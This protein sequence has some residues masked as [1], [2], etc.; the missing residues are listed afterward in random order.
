MT[1]QKSCSEKSNIVKNYGFSGKYFLGELK[2]SWPFA[3]FLFIAF[4]IMMPVAVLMG[5]QNVP[6]YIPV[7]RE[8]SDAE[9]LRHVMRIIEEPVMRVVWGVFIVGFGILS[10]LKIGTAL[11]NKVHSD[12]LHSLPI[13]RE[14]IFAT[15][16]L[17]TSAVFI[18]ALLVNSL[19]VV[20][21]CVVSSGLGTYGLSDIFAT[22]FAFFFKAL[23]LY[24]TAFSITNLA[25]MLSGTIVMQVFLTFFLGFAPLAYYLMVY[26]IAFTYADNISAD[27]YYTFDFSQKICPIVKQINMLITDAS[28]LDIFSAIFLNVLLI[29]ITIV[30]YK[31]RKVERAGTPVVFEPVAHVL[32][33]LCLIPCTFFVGF[34]FEAMGGNDEG[35]RIVGFIFGALLSFMF[36]NLILTKNARKMF[37]G[38]KG[39]GIYVAVMVLVIVGCSLNLF[40]IDTYV[41]K[42]DDLESVT[43]SVNGVA[44]NLEIREYKL[45]SEIL[46]TYADYIH[47]G[48]SETGGSP[49][50]YV[51]TADAIY[52]EVYEDKEI[53]KDSNYHYNLVYE[54]AE[55]ETY[56]NK[57]SFN[58]DNYRIGANMKL[59]FKLENGVKFAVK[60]H[61]SDAA[62]RTE[63]ARK[64]A[65]SAEFS[66][67][68]VKYLDMDKLSFASWT[69]LIK[70]TEELYWYESDNR[71]EEDA[72]MLAIME[73]VKAEYS[74]KNVFENNSTVVGYLSVRTKEPRIELEIPVFA[75]F[76]N[77]QLFTGCRDEEELF[78]KLSNM[79]EFMVICDISKVDSDTTVND[80]SVMITDNEFM[81]Q[82]FSAMHSLDS[83]YNSSYMVRDEQY[84]IL[85]GIKEAKYKYY[86]EE[87]DEYHYVTYLTR[88]EKG[89]VPE[90]VSGF[91]ASL[92][93]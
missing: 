53:Y 42:N 49:S 43:V 44:D 19:L 17:T 90:F 72:R 50:V 36:M 70:L 5:L 3:V 14:A 58:S 84:R 45:K 74:K 65:E 69:P 63:L 4:L 77:Q 18:G 75:S 57:I 12:F 82:A 67:E 26:G 20:L 83:D 41:P 51:E 46:R 9:I 87:P 81:R 2:R 73:A 21:A 62:K 71:P 28:A 31:M 93:K 11:T 13:R 35:W 78:V 23:L 56:T 22:V 8:I 80:C 64:I 52:Y 61:L 25:C 32:K 1:T 34:L 38:I 10:G 66:K 15:K 92:I 40:G 86:E 48:G 29:F 76:E 68:I 89:N 39:F 27:Y 59:V 54:N 79:A 7:V 24:F 55:G 60:M 91:L 33:Y 85:F 6:V 88:F 16:L 30:V 37:A 47:G